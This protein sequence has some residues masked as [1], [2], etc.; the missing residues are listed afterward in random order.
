LSLWVKGRIRHKNT[1]K[2]MICK[3]KYK[4]HEY[5]IRTKHTICYPG[6]KH[7]SFW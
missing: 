7:M 5:E 2:Q 6:Y 4:K 1:T 3:T